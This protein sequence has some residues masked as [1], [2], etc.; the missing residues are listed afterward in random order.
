M[1]QRNQTTNEGKVIPACGRLLLVI[2]FLLSTSASA[3]IL[4]RVVAIVDDESVL[5]SELED[6]YTKAQALG[7]D[8]KQDE[9]L[10]T[11]INRILLLKQAKKFVRVAEFARD[12]TLL[13]NEYINKRLKAFIRIPLEEIESFYKDNQ[14]S[15]AER[16][17]YDVR[18]EIEKYLVEKE[19]N[20]V[21]LNHIE[22]LRKKAYI[23]LQLKERDP[24]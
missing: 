17:F 12:E 19:T 15:F 5:L 10:D 23:R 16:S 7:T 6:S 21:L 1:Q 20:K 13:I 2:L 24:N 18:D 3:E 22:E 9:V 14:E 11:L 8:I 4:D